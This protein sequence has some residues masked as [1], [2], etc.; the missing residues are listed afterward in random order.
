MRVYIL[1]S[2]DPIFKPRLLHQILLFGKYEVCGVGEV[3]ALKRGGFINK[4]KFNLAFWG[5]GPFVSIAFTHYYRTVLE[6]LPLSPSINGI[7]S[8]KKVCDS[9]QVPYQLVPNV[10]APKFLTELREVEPDVILSFQH[11]IFRENILAIPNVTCINCHPALLP[12]YRGIKPIFWAMLNQDDYFGVTV[13]TMTREIDCG[14]IV[15]QIKIPLY[16]EHTMF[17]NS[18]AAY[19]LSAHVILDALNKLVSA[20]IEDFPPIPDSADYY[21]EPT[22]TDLQRFKEL[23]L[24]LY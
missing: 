4:L 6:K 22:Q 13:H 10:N 5:L 20:N 15:S 7:S 17:Q 1:F 9:Y 12:N 8:I 16:R 24:R 11:Q 19:E 23:G 3:T 18:I 21:R 14:K 2:D